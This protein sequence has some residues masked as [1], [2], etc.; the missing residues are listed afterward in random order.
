MPML[1]PDLVSVGPR[2]SGLSL[3]VN[4]V[5][6]WIVRSA[7]GY[8]PQIGKFYIQPELICSGR[9]TTLTLADET[10]SHADLVTSLPIFESVA[11]HHSKTILLSRATTVTL[12]FAVA[13][14]RQGEGGK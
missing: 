2:P 8:A 13:G 4:S 3:L 6:V 14:R 1:V 9:T 11:T 10:R 5:T 12:L 7:S